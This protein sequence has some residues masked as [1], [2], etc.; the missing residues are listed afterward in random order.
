MCSEKNTSPPISTPS[1]KRKALFVLTDRYPAAGGEQ[2]FLPQELQ[3]L[4]SL[5][6]NIYVVPYY[7]HQINSEL[8]APPAILLKVPFVHEPPRNPFR[9]VSV[10]RWLAK[11]LNRLPE[12]TKWW[13]YWVGRIVVMHMNSCLLEATLAELCKKEGFVPEECAFYCVWLDEL[14]GSVALLRLGKPRWQRAPFW[15]RA[16]RYDLYDIEGVPFRP[17]R[18][19]VLGQVQAV[20]VVSEEGKRWLAYR[21][22]AHADKFHTLYL[23]APDRGMAP[24]PKNN[25]PFRIV[26]ASAVIP[27]KRVTLIAEM[28]RHLPF[29]VEW[30]HF[31]DGSQMSALREAV[32]TLPPH[33]T[34]YLMG[35][36]PHEELMRFYR[37][38]P[39]HL[40][41]HT[42]V[43]EGLPLAVIEAASFGIPIVA[44]RA[45]GIAELVDQMCGALL[46]TDTSPQQLAHTIQNLK[47]SGACTSPTFRQQVRNRWAVLFHAHRVNEK[48]TSHVERLLQ[49]IA[50]II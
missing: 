6:E 40:F 37:E 14:A 9:L 5:F 35:N 30:F 17:L 20:F 15:A 49:S 27:R 44:T 4:S 1:H 39:V 48:L 47:N 33:I 7:H 46:P 19:L 11:D 18:E 10:V 42:A 32:L 8:P 16:H 2:A 21:Y 43:A 31:G 26:S 34:V 45:G 13:R 41:V 12:K 3:A 36:V 50:P 38:V 25:D 22:P 23:P 24:V 28:L 29:D